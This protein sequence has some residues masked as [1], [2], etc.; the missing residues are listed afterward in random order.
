VD[1]FREHFVQ[2]HRAIHDG[3]KLDGYYAWSLMDNF[4]WARGYSKRFGLIFI[5]YKTQERIWKKSSVWYSDV[6]Q[7]NGI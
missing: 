7:N 6:I 5:D 2:A 4:E 1:F 3:V